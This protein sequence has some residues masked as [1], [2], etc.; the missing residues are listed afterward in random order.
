MFCARCG[1]NIPDDSAFC[2]I[3]GRRASLDL[4][5]TPVPPAAVPNNPYPS[6]PQNFGP[7]GVGGWLL[8]Y[9]SYSML[10]LFYGFLLLT[11]PLRLQNPAYL[12][13]AIRLLYGGVVGIF[14][15][16]KHSIALFLLRIYF[17]VIGVEL[18]FDI[19]R[20]VSL[21]VQRHTSPFTMTNFDSTMLAVSMSVAWLAYFRYS[22]RVRNTYGRNI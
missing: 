11:R 19:L 3:C 9:C 13:A 15:W 5:P 2:Q 21:A 14:L 8:L 17:V 18:L 10:G 7:S 6:I 20:L 4:T 16:T 22:V 12:L 1:Q